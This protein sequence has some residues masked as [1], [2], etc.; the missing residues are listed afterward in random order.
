[1]NGW[2]V[3]VIGPDDI[4]PAEDQKAAVNLADRINNRIRNAVNYYGTGNTS[5]RWAVPVP[6]NQQAALEP[7]Q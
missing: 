6:P 2:S 3:H 4:Y 5:Y 7:K 1:M